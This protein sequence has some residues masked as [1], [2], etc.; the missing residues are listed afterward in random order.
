[1]AVDLAHRS[2]GI[3][4]TLI[5]AVVREIK[6]KILTSAPS[7]NENENENEQEQKVLLMLTT[8]KEKNEAYYLRRGFR[9][10]SERVFKKGEMGSRD[11]FCV[12]EME[13]VF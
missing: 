1:M 12:V 8:M 2:R 13:G 10:T 4:T 3:A 6:Y 11:G 5:H 7:S 9:T